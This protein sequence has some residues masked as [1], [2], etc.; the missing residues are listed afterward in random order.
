MIIVTNLKGES[1]AINDELIERVE[2]DREARII[3]TGGARYIVAESLD[4]VVRRSREDR[5]VVRAAARQLLD[6]AAPGD[7]AAL[8]LLTADPADAG[9]PPG[10]TEGETP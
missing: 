5:A 1:I 4:E 2:G 6:G 9:D 7:G 10:A 8:R 3:L